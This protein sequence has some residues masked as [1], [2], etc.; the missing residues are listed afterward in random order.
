L[1]GGGQLIPE[2]GIGRLVAINALATVIRDLTNNP[3][4]GLGV[5]EVFEHCPTVGGYGSAKPIPGRH[6][7]G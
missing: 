5:I 7:F 3:G 4:E 1:R 6:I 2:F